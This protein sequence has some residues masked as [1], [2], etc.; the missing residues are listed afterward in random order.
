MRR[1]DEMRRRL[2]HENAFTADALPIRLSKGLMQM[3]G[4]ENRTTDYGFKLKWG[5]KH[6]KFVPRTSKEVDYMNR[7]RPTPLSLLY[8][9]IVRH[10]IVGDE[11]GALLQLVPVEDFFGKDTAVHYV[12]RQLIFHPVVPYKIKN[13]RFQMF[14]TD[15]TKNNLVSDIT[16]SRRGSMIVTLLFRRKGQ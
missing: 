3:M 12:P 14:Q 7:V 10:S 4:H 6:A 1:L 9:D 8:C 16:Q 5:R 13:I 11:R 15:G 2:H